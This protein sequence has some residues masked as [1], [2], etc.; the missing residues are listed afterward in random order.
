M[1]LLREGQVGYFHSANSSVWTGSVC[2]S[3]F[4]KTSKPAQ[5]TPCIFENAECSSVS[6]II[7][8]Y[9][10]RRPLSQTDFAKI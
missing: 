4:I 1:S 7:I 2:Y 6:I 9:R 5:G 3:G 8:I 10:G